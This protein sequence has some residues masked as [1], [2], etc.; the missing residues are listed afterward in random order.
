ML[1]KRKQM[2]NTY[3]KRCSA[4]LEISEIQVKTTAQALECGANGNVSSTTI[5]ENNLM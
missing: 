4:L 2:S 5:L 1:Q 3:V